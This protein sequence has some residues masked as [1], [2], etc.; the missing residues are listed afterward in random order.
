MVKTRS[1][2][3]ETSESEKSFVEQEDKEQDESMTESKDGENLNSDGSQAEK[4]LSM[5]SN[6]EMEVEDTEK[7]YLNIS[8]IIYTEYMALKNSHSKVN[9]LKR[10]F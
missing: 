9:H 3:P 8:Q 1:M 10:K 4:N 7:I 5:E 6:V 2:E